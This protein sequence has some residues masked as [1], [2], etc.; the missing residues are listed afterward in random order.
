MNYTERYQELVREFRLGSD[1]RLS[2]SG[3]D[4]QFFDFKSNY[5]SQKQGGVNVDTDTE[6]FQFVYPV[7]VPAKTR[8]FDKAIL[9]L[10]GLNERS[11]NKYLTWAEYI[12]SQLK[13]PVILFPIAYHIN[14]SPL[15]WFNLRGLRQMTEDR[16]TSNGNDKTTTVANVILSQRISDRPYRFYSSGRQSYADVTD[17]VRNIK[18]GHHPLFTENAHIDIFAYSIGAFLSQVIL[19]T[20][21]DNIFSDSKLFMFC[22]G[23]IFSS[24]FGESRSIMDGPAFQ[25]LV[26]YYVDDFISDTSVDVADDNALNAFNSMIS[27]ERDQTERLSCFMKMKNRISGI[28]LVRDRVIPYKGVKEALGDKCA[29]DIIKLLDFKHD[30]CHENP[31]P[32]GG[33]IDSNEVNHSFNT[34]FKQ[35]IDFLG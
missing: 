32:V 8:K 12:A 9:L 24:M 19:L 34:V 2:S 25:K 1:L 30:Y 21:P 22:G 23:S 26:K 33:K 15:G 6:N 4:I 13:R 14:R 5:I 27:P 20:N 10:H 18:Q 35:A 31:F 29:S 28:S 11:W 3:I 17:L 16:K 7:F